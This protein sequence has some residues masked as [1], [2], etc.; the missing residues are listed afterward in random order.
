MV[1]FKTWPK[2]PRLQ[3]VN[4][5]ITEKIDGTNSCVIVENG[6][7]VGCQSRNRLISPDN[8]NFG[9][10]A[11]VEENKDTLKT[12]GDGYHYGEWAGPGIQKNPH[13]LS[14]KKFFLF[15]SYRWNTV[16]E[17]NENHPA[18]EIVSVVPTY[19][20]RGFSSEAIMEAALQLEHHLWGLGSQ[21]TE[22]T[23]PE[24]LIIFLYP[25]NTY[26]KLHLPGR[27]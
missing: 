18:R 6:E 8:D 27:G 26:F 9:F 7:V 2:I 15:N 22:P 3:K 19:G 11:W 23:K 24:G 5:T 14:E 16:F 25:T 4:M 21:A 20:T 13:L 17:K 12:L 10:A 1:E